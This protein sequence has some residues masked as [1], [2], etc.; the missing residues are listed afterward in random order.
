MK[1]AVLLVLENNSERKKLISQLIAKISAGTIKHSCR[2]CFFCFL[3]FFVLESMKIQADHKKSINKA[4][5]SIPSTFG[6][7]N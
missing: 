6:Q 3:C 1:E 4:I 7:V 5:K 2:N